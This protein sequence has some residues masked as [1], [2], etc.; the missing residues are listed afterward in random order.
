[1][2]TYEYR[3]E[4][5]KHAFEKFQPITAPAV[6][7]CPKCGK[8]KVKRLLSVGAGM[9]FKGSG[10]YITDYRSE[11]YKEQAKAD[12]SASP[13]TDSAAKPDSKTE[14][15]S[16]PKS[17]PKSETKSDSKSESRSESKSEARPTPAPPPKESKR[18]GGK[19]RSKE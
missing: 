1:M 17:E 2:P 6:R 7:K 10:F 3:C 8:N 9:I 5:C 16:E 12:S 18:D 13:P 15:K 19:S 14:S 4:A 11:G